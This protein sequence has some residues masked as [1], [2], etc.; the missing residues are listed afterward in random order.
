MHVLM[1]VYILTT[2]WRNTPSW[3]PSRML[4][5]RLIPVDG[6]AQPISQWNR[7]HENECHFIA[8]CLLWI[9]RKFS[10]NACDL[11]IHITS[12]TPRQDN[13]TIAQVTM[14]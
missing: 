5:A 8:L 12:L 7:L 1:I 10:Q 11:F 13:L 3:L 2:F 4:W 14:K 6:V 9:C